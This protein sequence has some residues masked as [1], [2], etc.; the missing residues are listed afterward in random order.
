MSWSGAKAIIKGQEP[1]PSF[2]EALADV[3]ERQVP[4]LF[5]GADSLR[6]SFFGRGI[7]LCTIYNGKSGRCSEDCIFCAQSIHHSAQ[8]TEYGLQ[9]VDKLQ[10]K[11]IWAAR[12]PINRYSIVTSGHGLKGNEVEHVA[13]S[14]ERLQ[15]EEISVCTSLG[16]LEKDS[17]QRLASAGVGRYHHNLEAPRSFFPNVCTTHTFEERVQTLKRAKSLG[18][19][20]CSGGVFGLGE[21]DQQVLEMAME[22]RGLSVDAIPLNFLTPIPGT[23]AEHLNFLTPLRCLKIIAIFRYVLPDKDIIVCGGRKYNLGQFQSMMFL[24]GASG[25]MTGDY[26]TTKGNSLEEDLQ[27][28]DQ[29][30]LCPREKTKGRDLW[31]NVDRGP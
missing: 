24:A 28:I 6:E 14:M 9:G 17:L 29:L 16:I 22:L 4:S 18:F 5:P 1:D 15:D 12:T 21:S 8:I 19:S 25:L 13:Q 10:S 27:L 2:F 11:G 30:G 26:L 7:H 20:L 23:P 31:K 3:P